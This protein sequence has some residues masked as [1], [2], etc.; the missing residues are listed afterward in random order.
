MANHF[1]DVSNIFT[2]SG[3]DSD[4]DS[5]DFVIRRRKNKTVHPFSDYSDSSVDE[6]NDI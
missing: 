6:N 1:S 4:S 2:N 5:E 3:S